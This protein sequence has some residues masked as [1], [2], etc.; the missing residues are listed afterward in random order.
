M[1]WFIAARQAAKSG[2]A[3]GLA[4]W[5]FSGMAQSFTFQAGNAK[6][7]E[8][9]GVDVRTVDRVLPKL[10]GAGLIGIVS[11]PG[12]KKTITLKFRTGWIQ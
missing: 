10:V 11:R 6:I 1:D 4:L 9:A 2:Q 8:V 3:V 7:A 12:V 5:H